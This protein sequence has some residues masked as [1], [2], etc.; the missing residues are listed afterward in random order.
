M[1]L[2]TYN[3]KLVKTTLKTSGERNAEPKQSYGQIPRKSNPAPWVKGV[4]VGQG[5]LPSYRC[6]VSRFGQKC[7]ISITDL[8]HRH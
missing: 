1:G 4:R 6:S 5:V 3:S 2:S 7:I 8:D